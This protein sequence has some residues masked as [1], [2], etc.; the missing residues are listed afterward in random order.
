M[1]SG[2]TAWET[3]DTFL[4]T[5]LNQKTR[6]V[7]NS[8]QINS[9]ITSP[10]IG[11]VSFSTSTGS[12]FSDNKTYV[13]N[14]ANTTWS[15]NTITS[16][17]LT[18]G[19]DSDYNPDTT[20]MISKANN[21]LYSFLTL[22][23][24]YKFYLFTQM[25]IGLVYWTP[26]GGTL[27]LVFGIDLVDSITPTIQ[28]T[29]LVAISPKFSVTGSIGQG[30]VN[31]TQ[32]I[33]S[34]PVIGGS[35]LGLWINSNTTGTDYSF[36]RSLTTSTVYQKAEVITETPDTVNTTAWV[37]STFYEPHIRITGY[38]YN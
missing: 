12:G 19:L 21:R 17:A 33:A 26:S 14:A 6:F 38:G 2:G 23:T 18:P 37:T 11:Q 8:D 20:G 3:V 4:E 5:R 1:G 30:S 27:S 32:N 31:T 25:L 29:P 34:K 24:T 10:Q 35:V 15:T 7:G 28:N 36:R 9:L 22:P 13:R 16:T